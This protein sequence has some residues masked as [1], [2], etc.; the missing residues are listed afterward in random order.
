MI[1]EQKVRV[2]WHHNNKEHYISKGYSFTKFGDELEV[3]SLDLT[4]SPTN[5]VQFICDYCNGGNQKEECSKWKNTSNLYRHRK[6][7]NK[8][9][10]NH[11]VCREVKRKESYLIKLKKEHRTL[12]DVHPNIAT[13]WSYKNKRSPYEY[14]TSS[15]E[16]VWW[17]CKNNPNHE[18]RATIDNRTN[19]RG[20]PYCAGKSVC[21]DNCLETTHIELSKEWNYVKNNGLTPKDVTKGSHERVWWIGECGHEW[22]DT[23]QHR[24]RG[25]GCPY[26]SGK[27]VSEE[28]CL[29]YNSPELVLEWD[30]D[31]NSDLTPY[32]ITKSSNK[33]VWWVC[34]K[35]KHNWESIIGNRNR[36][37]GCPKCSESK[38]EKVISNWLE[39]NLIHFRSQKEF[40]GLVG[41]GGGN[42]SYDFFLPNK[43]ILI[44]YQGEFHDGSAGGYSLINL[45]KQ[46]EHDKRKR[47]YAESHNIYLLEIW[48]WDITNIEEILTRELT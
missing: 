5:I 43:N 47:E 35:C 16:S 14:S 22:D 45:E 15:G 44:E 31:K 4:I 2:K 13:E 25:V 33:S 28:N 21:L 37:V 7:T 32:N 18:W 36:G 10:C 23:I 40:D 11:A 17:K 1:V 34:K 29:A 12:Q 19:G 20:C 9:C 27:R 39:D 46:Q 26:C 42:L 41:I 38:G 8:D 30:Y 48:H 3:N 6:T 24:S